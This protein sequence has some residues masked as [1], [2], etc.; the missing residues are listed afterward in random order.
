MTDCEYENS[1]IRKKH[2]EYNLKRYYSN[3]KLY[4]K[5]MK[6]Y[7]Q[8][9][10]SWICRNCII[11]GKFCPKGNKKYCK[12]CSDLNKAIMKKLRGY[13]HV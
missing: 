11:C 1:E 13:Y 9:H 2:R 5:K 3:P 8:S 7:Y 12:D 4:T 10:K 6:E